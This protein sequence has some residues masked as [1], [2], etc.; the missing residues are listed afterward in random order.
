MLGKCG[1]AYQRNVGIGPMQ[2]WDTSLPGPMDLRD[3]KCFI[4]TAELGSITRASGEL[5]LV[6]SALSR[7]VQALEEEL[8][9]TLFNRLP[10]GIQLTPAGRRFLDRA[11]RIVREVE[12]ARSDAREGGGELSG[13]VSLG[14]SP[15]LAPLLAPDCLAQ[16]AMDAP[17]IQLKIVEGFSS[18]L[19][20]LLLTGRIDLAVL[21]N[22]PRTTMLRQ[23]PSVSEE[24]LVVTPPGARG[25]QPFFSLDELCNEPVVVTSGLRTVIEEQLHKHGRALNVVAEIDSVEAIRRMV[26]RGQAVTLMPA[27][28]FHED[29]RE[30]RLDAFHV[31]HASLHRLLVI[32]RPLSGRDT[33]AIRQ[34]AETL[35]RQFSALSD[36]GAFRLQARMSRKPSKPKRERS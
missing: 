15:T 19:L 13:A 22:P 5:G 10:R 21:T 2:E 20:D 12:F 23:E 36:A 29:V 14:L 25:I 18:T 17:G 4:L 26:M 32:A 31:T 11:R 33:P 7:K 9:C 6:Q 27:S 35:A 24:I 30:H 3:L 28:T 34:V 16:T 8:G 1:A